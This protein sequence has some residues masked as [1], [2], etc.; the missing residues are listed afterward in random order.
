MSGYAACAPGGMRSVELVEASLGAASR[1]PADT[2]LGKRLPSRRTFVP[3][4][5]FD[6]RSNFFGRISRLQ[7][8]AARG[9]LGQAQ[10]RIIC[11]PLRTGPGPGGAPAASGGT[12]MQLDLA[13]SRRS[14][15][16]SPTEDDIA[17]RYS[18][19]GWGDETERRLLDDLFD[20]RRGGFFR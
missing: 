12:P 9:C 10:W 13:A 15:P 4:D 2:S 3:V 14:S 7:A 18:G 5:R 17:D 8:R 11:K 6:D 16:V 1:G 20:G 19:C